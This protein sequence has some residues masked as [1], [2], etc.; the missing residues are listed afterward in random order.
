M[1]FDEIYKSMILSEEA[2]LALVDEYTLYCFYTGIDPLIPGKA[3]HA[4]YYRADN[5]PSFSIFESRS[6]TL[7]YMWKDHGTG[8]CGSIFHLIKK[9]EQLS[10][11]QEVLSRIN[12][13]FALGFNT[14]D[15]VRK[16][17]QIW[18]EKPKQDQIKIRIKT[19]T[20][21]EKG[22]AF[23]DQFEIKDDL[24]SLY[25]VNQVE[26][27]WSYISQVAPTTAPDPMFSYRVG[28][29]Y[30][31]YSPY[32]NKQY[33]FRNDLP[34]NYFFGYL[35]L[36]T[37]GDKLIIDKSCKDVIFCK[38]LGYYA[39]A[40]KSETTMVPHNKMLELKDR[41]NKIYLMLDPDKAGMNQ[42]AKYKELYPWLEVKFLGRAKDK[43]DLALAVGIAESERIIKQIINEGSN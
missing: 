34:E 42:T 26:F 6:P 39:I 36:P 38:K 37:T 2:V 1:D 18:Y 32:V 21:T 40:G 16:E 13:D 7:E 43:T 8:E 3:Y 20:F 15:P 17:K 28:E 4:P 25:N 41:F 22:R 35:Q 24:L 14:T 9:V 5:F 27:Y 10:T 29:Y 11:R 23:W 30:Q 31:L 33:K 12:E 19:Q